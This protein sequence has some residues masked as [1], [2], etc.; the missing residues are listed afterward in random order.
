S[1]TKLSLQE[2]TL[3]ISTILQNI[4]E[5]FSPDTT[6]KELQPLIDSSGKTLYDTHDKLIF[7]HERFDLIMSILSLYTIEK[8]EEKLWNIFFQEYKFLFAKNN[9]IYKNKNSQD[10]I[11][12]FNEKKELL[13]HFFEL[14]FTNELFPKS[15][16]EEFTRKIIS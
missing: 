10:F 16:K 14:L 12:N 6:E 11:F 9:T 4:A 13:K 8:L 1:E 15:P 2:K 5:L 7:L 3:L